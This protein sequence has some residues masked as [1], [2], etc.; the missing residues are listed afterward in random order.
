MAR[1]L[2]GYLEMAKLSR[3]Q[4]RHPDR[5]AQSQRDES[6]AKLNSFLWRLVMNQGGKLKIPY[7]QI[8]NI[9]AGAGIEV[10]NVPGTEFI[11]IKAVINSPIATLPKRIQI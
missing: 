4:R 11:E 7:D 8:K 6:Q 9:P 5:F 1:I 2:I 3:Q 10:D